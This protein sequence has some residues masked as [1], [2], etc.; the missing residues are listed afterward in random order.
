MPA[1]FSLLTHNLPYPCQH[2]VLYAYT[3]TR[4][5]AHI[6]T[7]P[8]IYMTK[9]RDALE[10]RNES[11]GG[12]RK[13]SERP[14][15]L[16]TFHCT[17]EQTELTVSRLRPAKRKKQQPK[18]NN[19]NQPSS[20]RIQNETKGDLFPASINVYIVFMQTHIKQN[21]TKITCFPPFFFKTQ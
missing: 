13:D 17:R 19:K 10:P 2:V 12:R 3:H 20:S 11:R 16:L 21:A 1:S 4:F 18:N 9:P 5:K 8:H 6:L 15:R 7:I 14:T